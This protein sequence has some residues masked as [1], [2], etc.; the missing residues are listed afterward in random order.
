MSENPFDRVRLTWQRISVVP[1]KL[2][3][4]GRMS[5]AV[6]QNQNLRSSK[7]A[8]HAER[9]HGALCRL[10]AVALASLLAVF[11]L[12]HVAAEAA[13]PTPS[14]D[15]HARPAQS[16]AQS[17]D[18]H[19]PPP[20]AKEHSK[21]A[22]SRGRRGEPAQSKDRQVQPG[23]PKDRH[24]KPAQSKDPHGQARHS[25]HPAGPKHI[26]HGPDFNPPTRT[27]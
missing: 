24:G 25:G 23:V 15:R 7:P 4:K 6:E 12:S 13:L 21:P 22:Q 10:G 17:K 26:L 20:Q 11:A 9:R 18:P 27:F 8:L 19:T 16:P 5:V 2:L 1:S 3:R 14:K